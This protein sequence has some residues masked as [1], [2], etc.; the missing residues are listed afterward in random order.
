MDIVKEDF[1]ERVKEIEVYLRAI[2]QVESD[3]YLFLKTTSKRSRRVPL[4]DDLPKIMKAAFFLILYNLVESCVRSC[5]KELYSAITSER[6]C[7]EDFEVIFRKLWV[8]KKFKEI[9]PVSSN[10][11]TYRELVVEMIEDVVAKKEF[12]IPG[13]EISL[14]G[15]LDARKTRE[16]LQQ[17]GVPFKT[18]YRAF[19]GGQLA[20]IKHNRNSLAHGHIS[21]SEC[22]RDFTHESLSRI[23]SETVVFL[24]S[25]MRNVERY[26]ADAGYARRSA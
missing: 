14:S 8:A 18:H 24:R 21:F 20:T 13:E 17:H 1:R 10:Q 11:K 25:V 5:L 23:K 22:G 6:K 7:I 4:N 19:G 15:S 16:I 12:S 9:D 3:E 2:E 26:I